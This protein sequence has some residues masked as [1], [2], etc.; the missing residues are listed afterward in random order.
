MWYPSGAQLLAIAVDIVLSF[1]LAWYGSQRKI[2]FTPALLISLI[3]T[4]LVGF[5]FVTLSERKDKN[6]DTEGLSKK[7][8]EF[9]IE[10][11]RRN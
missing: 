8:T 1:V 7:P 10:Q 6:D 3:L 2:G 5:F 9:D 11:F 4:P